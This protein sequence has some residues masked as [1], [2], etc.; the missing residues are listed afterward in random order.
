MRF[1]KEGTRTWKLLYIVAII[2]RPF[3]VRLN[4]EGEENV[5]LDGGCVIASNHTLGADYVLL[6][7]ASPRQIF[8][9]AKSEIFASHPL[10]AKL[11]AGAGAFPVQRGKA[12]TQAIDQ[13]IAIVKTG[14]I[15]GMFPEGTRS[16]NGVLRRAKPGAARIALGAGAPIVP[17]AVVNGDTI[18][19]D[20]LKPQRR[21]LVTVRFGV[22]LAPDGSA[23]DPL[24]VEQLTTAMMLA[25]AELLPTERRGHYADAATLS[26]EER[27]AR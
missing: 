2:I 20:F 8:Y 26:A 23:D 18:L 27:A 24:D 14:K 21:P 10:V 15:V 3:F 25:V 5:P 1:P 9:M 11:V 6:G 22:P 7:Y 17:A 12:D 16:R 19:R 13:A 4:I